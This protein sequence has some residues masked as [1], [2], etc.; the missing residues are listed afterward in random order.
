M[1]DFFSAQC[2]VLFHRDATRERSLTEVADTSF[3]KLT[4]GEGGIILPFSFLRPFISS[5]LF[6]SFS[7]PTFFLLVLFFFL[8]LE[9]RHFELFS[10]FSCF[11]SRFFLVSLLFLFLFFL[12][13]TVVRQGSGCTALV[14]AVLAR[15]LELT[16]AEKHVHNFMMDNQLTKRVSF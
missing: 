14:V 16:R 8:S 1:F 3:N 5:F 10:S 7:F 9:V 12:S 4:N 15:K 6:P 13:N 2:S 11:C